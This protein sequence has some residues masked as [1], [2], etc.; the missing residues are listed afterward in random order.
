MAR[1]GKGAKAGI[2]I[3]AVAAAAVMVLVSLM[4]AVAVR[5]NKLLDAV[6]RREGQCSEYIWSADDVYDPDDYPS[7]VTPD[8]SLRILQLTDI[9]FRNQGTFGAKIGVNDILDSMFGSQ[10]KKLVEQYD[11]DLIVVTGDLITVEYAD[12]AYAM[13]GDVIQSLG[14]KWTVTMGNHDATY[15]SDKLALFNVFDDAERYPDYIFSYGPTNFTHT[16]TETDVREGAEALVGKTVNTGIGNFAINIKNAAGEITGAVVLMDSN[17]WNLEE[18]PEYKYSTPS[19][20]FYP[21][22][23]EWYEWL[24]EGLEEYAGRTVPT[25]LFAH[26]G[27]GVDGTNRYGMGETVTAK[28]STTAVFYGHTHG[29]GRFVQSQF[30]GKE[31]MQVNGVKAGWQYMENSNTGGTVIDVA[32]DGDL[33]VKLVQA[34]AVSAKVV[35][36]RRIAFGEE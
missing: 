7:V 20:D 13:L 1:L 24:I 5:E 35:Q 15:N 34:N 16:V 17:D 27:I 14:V 30:G 23:V 8:G 18:H 3:A 28:G 4:I 9:H 10:A 36:E 26:I 22:Q 19:A 33:T 25:T 12:E 2:A 31:I 11:P 29:E 32:P 21:M 6:Q